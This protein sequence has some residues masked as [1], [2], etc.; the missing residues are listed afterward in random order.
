MEAC[1]LG[2]ICGILVYDLE[3]HPDG[4]GADLD[5]FVD[6]DT[7]QIS[8]PEDVNNVYTTRDGFEVRV[9]LLTEYLILDGVDGN[10]RLAD[11]LE[12]GRDPVGGTLGFGREAYDGPG[13]R[14]GEEI[15]DH[16]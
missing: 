12:L 3:L 15:V 6:V 7:S 14:V 11:R 5:G 4:F 10:D 13:L 9:A 16:C 8:T 2:P 1:F